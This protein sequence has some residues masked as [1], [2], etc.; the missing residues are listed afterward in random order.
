[1]QSANEEIERFT[2]DHDNSVRALTE[3]MGEGWT[4][5]QLMPY[6]YFLDT[7]KWKMDLE[8]QKKKAI[9]E[10]NRDQEADYKR[11]MNAQRAAEKRASRGRGKR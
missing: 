7:I 9:E 2:K 3:L 8:D 5:I 10:R 6:S 11:R 1:M 4:S